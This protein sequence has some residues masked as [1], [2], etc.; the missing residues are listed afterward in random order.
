MEFS[1]RQRRALE[2]GEFH[3]DS[4]GDN[5]GLYREACALEA[6]GLITIHVNDYSQHSVYN[7]T[8]TEKG[9]ALIAAFNSIR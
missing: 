9:R 4:G 8:V 7:C 3:F 1:P 2:C 6:E 5:V